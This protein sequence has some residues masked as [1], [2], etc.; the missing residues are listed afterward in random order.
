MK[1]LMLR[2][3]AE[4]A[5]TGNLSPPGFLSSSCHKLF[6]YHQLKYFVFLKLCSFMLLFISLML[7]IMAEGA[8]TGDLS[9]LY[10]DLATGYF[11]IIA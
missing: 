4:G 8:S 9:S 1:C 6:E 5:S 2:I 10:P 3:M 7:K 11:N